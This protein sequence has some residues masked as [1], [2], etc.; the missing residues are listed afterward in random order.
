MNNKD[1]EEENNNN[2]LKLKLDEE[3]CEVIQHNKNPDNEGEGMNPEHTEEMIG[4]P[5]TITPKLLK[6]ITVRGMASGYRH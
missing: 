1:N 5:N 3:E 6:Y 2:I 4:I